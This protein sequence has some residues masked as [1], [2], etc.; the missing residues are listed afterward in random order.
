MSSSLTHRAPSPESCGA[1]LVLRARPAL[2]LTRHITCL[3]SPSLGTPRACPQ[4]HTAHHVPALNLT[5]HTTCL[6]SP[7]HGTPRACPQPHTAHHV[8]ALTLTRHTQC[9]PSTSLGTS[10]ACPQPHTAH[11][12][13]ALNLTRHTQCLPSTSHGTPSACPRPPPC[14][15]LTCMARARQPR[16]GKAPTLPS[17]HMYG[18]GSTAKEGCGVTARLEAMEMTTGLR[19]DM[20]SFSAWLISWYALSR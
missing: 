19:R 15:H 20:A 17:S 8:P 11:P 5:R 9:L 13:P 6:P 18:M 12:V 2:T 4:P 14:P 10:R 7:S 16:T 3:P 1:Q